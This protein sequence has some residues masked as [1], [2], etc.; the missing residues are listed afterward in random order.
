MAQ[1]TGWKTSTPYY[2]HF[3]LHELRLYRSC[4]KGAFNHSI[5]DRSYSRQSRGT[6]QK[7]T[8][9]GFDKELEDAATERQKEAKVFFEA[10]ERDF[11]AKRY[12]AAATGYQKSVEVLAT[13]SAYLNLGTVLSTIAEFTKAQDAFIA[14]L[15]IGRRK[16]N[17]QFE[18]ALLN[19]IGGVY[20]TQGKLKEALASCQ[21][22]LQLYKQASNS[23]GQANALNNIGSVYYDQGKWE[24][25]LDRLRQAHDLYQKIGVKTMESQKVER[26]I[27]RLMTLQ[28][29]FDQTEKAK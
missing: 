5:T 24:E 8:T 21:T 28:R 17:S 6:V 19:N 2:C 27:Q 22:A 10:A 9:S 13:M 11:D 4:G 23:L 16:K 12:Q 1:N 20:A 26:R 7:A 14:G 15:Q 29:N 25:A 18:A 3:C